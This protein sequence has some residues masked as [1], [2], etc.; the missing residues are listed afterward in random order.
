MFVREDLV[1]RDRLEKTRAADA[2][3]EAMMN[4]FAAE[5]G[6]RR[7]NISKVLRGTAKKTLDA[8]MTKFQEQKDAA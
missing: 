2:A 5:L 3:H 1:L 6:C 7:A 4:F 8:I